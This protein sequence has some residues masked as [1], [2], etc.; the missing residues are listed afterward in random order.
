MATVA[1]FALIAL[2]EWLRWGLGFGTSLDALP[3]GS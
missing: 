1:V 2:W 3:I